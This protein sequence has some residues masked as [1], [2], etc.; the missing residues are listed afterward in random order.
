MRVDVSGNISQAQLVIAAAA[1][2]TRGGR[3][4][5]VAAGRG[6]RGCSRGGGGGGG[7]GVA[8]TAAAAARDCRG[9]I[10]TVVAK[11]PFTA[12][13]A[14]DVAAA[15]TRAWKISLVTSYDAV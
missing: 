12:A 15:T 4:I 14:A 9:V 3:G 7:G 8:S 5:A 13:A 2:A 1:A 6:G 11:D 10:G